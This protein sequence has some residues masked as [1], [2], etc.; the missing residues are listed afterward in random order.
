M[1]GHVP[2]TCDTTGTRFTYGING[3]FILKISDEEI[4][5][6]HTLDTQTLAI[7]T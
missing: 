1:H 5:W 4:I 3:I 6:N 7:L 2:I